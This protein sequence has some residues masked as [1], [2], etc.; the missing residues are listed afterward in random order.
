MN[1]YLL[2]VFTIKYMYTIFINR[3]IRYVRNY[4]SWVYNRVN[5]AGTYCQSLGVYRYLAGADG[6]EKRTQFL[7]VLS[8]ESVIL[9][10]YVLC[11]DIYE[12]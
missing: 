1:L 6:P 7:V 2:W 9:V 3:E 4:N 5:L 11:R 10:D 8:S 12:R